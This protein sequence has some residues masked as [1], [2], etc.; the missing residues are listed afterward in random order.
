M[1]RHRHTHTH[2]NGKSMLKEYVDLILKV[3]C[4]TAKIPLVVWSNIITE[5]IV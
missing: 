2:R 4:T 5:Y 1:Y 3:R